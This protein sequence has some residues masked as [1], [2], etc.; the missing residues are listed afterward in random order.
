MK[1]WVCFSVSSQ[2]QKNYIKKKV[3]KKN[4]WKLA[5]NPA[6]VCE[7]WRQPV[8]LRYLH[9]FTRNLTTFDNEFRDFHQPF[10][11]IIFFQFK[12]RW[13]RSMCCV[14]TQTYAHTYMDIA[15]VCVCVCTVNM[16]DIRSF[17]GFH[18]IITT[19]FLII[20]RPRLPS[21]QHAPEP[22]PSPKT[23]QKEVTHC[24]PGSNI[25]KHN[26]ELHN[27]SQCPFLFRFTSIIFSIGQ[28]RFLWLWLDTRE[29]RR[30]NHKFRETKLCKQR[31]FH[32][33]MNLFPNHDYFKIFTE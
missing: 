2:C 29:A 20:L 15:C 27:L 6:K 9:S 7:K 5:W 17:W 3:S 4:I 21:F 23:I 26:F 32:S 8:L 22:S 25:S 18:I 19:F 33:K 13:P 12:T 14:S 31:Q 24:T 28:T 16:H 1:N 10:P 11:I 30:R